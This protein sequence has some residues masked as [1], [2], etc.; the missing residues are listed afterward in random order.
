MLNE[1]LSNFVL[2]PE[3]KL[4]ACVQE[5]N[6]SGRFE[7]EKLPRLEVCPKCAT[8]SQTG[9]DRRTVRIKDSP[10]RGNGTALVIT[11][12][13]LWCAPCKKMKAFLPNL[14]QDCGGRLKVIY[15][16]YD[17]NPQLV[18]AMKVSSVPALMLFQGGI[19][20]KRYSGFVSQEELKS[21]ILPLLKP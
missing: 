13:R 5:D 10:I 2:L 1:S 12:R 21:S 9:Y 16:D 8:P 6:S 18:A 15:V 19:E 11:K 3:L 20:K 4:T 17:H 14:I 7:C